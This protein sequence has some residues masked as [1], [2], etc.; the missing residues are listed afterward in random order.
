MSVNEM[1]NPLLQVKNLHKSFGK[2]HVLQGVNADIYKGD[3]VAIIGPSGCGKSTFL[4]CLNFLEMPTAGEI[5]FNDEL[6]Y[7]NERVYLKR[8][9]KALLALKKEKK[10]D[11]IKIG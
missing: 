5:S 9:M 11:I 10:Y 3:V 4:R 6:I 2:L 1:Q 7:K 8:Q